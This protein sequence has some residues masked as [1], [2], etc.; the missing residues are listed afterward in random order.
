M[1]PR[2]QELADKAQQY[3]EYMTPQGLDCWDNFKEQFAWL[4]IKESYQVV[5]SNPNISTS[6]AGRNM[7][8]HFGLDGDE[9]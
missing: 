7:L 9:E 1:N 4:I 3:A 2:I 6:L 5:T 8:N